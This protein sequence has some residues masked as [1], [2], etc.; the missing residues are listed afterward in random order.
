MRIFLP[1]VTR[2]KKA[3][4][5]VA[6]LLGVPLAQSQRAVAR[7]CGYRDWHELEGGLASSPHSPLDTE[8][9]YDDFVQRHA[10][11]AL[12]LAGAL[13]IPDGD[14]QHALS[15]ARL[16]GDRPPNLA[17]QIAIRLACFRATSMPLSAPRMPGAV[18]RLKSSGLD[19]QVVILRESGKATRVVSHGSSSMLVADFEYI[20]PRTPL[21]L[22]LPMRLHMPYGFWT[23]AEGSIVVFSR[24][25]KP[26]WR[27]RPDSS[28][29]R[30]EPWLW[31]RHVR[32]TYLWQVGDE[33]WE[34][35]DVAARLEGW[36]AERSILGLPILADALPALVHERHASMSDAARLLQ[37]ARSPAALLATT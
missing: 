2:P 32:E 24:D 27:I 6:R 21:P 16:T 13:G 12:G 33:P 11:L 14:A 29:E 10:R 20:T 9:A 26:M 23:E 19:G 30:V 7:A 8:L 35:P 36:L 28:V 37:D 4:K 22:F 18:G 1:N 34:N 3:A 17:D 5:H 25:Y 15:G 31:I